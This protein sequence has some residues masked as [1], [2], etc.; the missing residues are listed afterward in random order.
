MLKMD[1]VA[2]RRGPR[3]I[4]DNVQLRAYAG[5]KIG[6]VGANGVGKSSLF[7]LVTGE[8]IPDHG[9]VTLPA[10]WVIAHVGQHSPSTTDCAI[11]FVLDG[12][13][14]LRVLER[15]LE[16][17]DGSLQK[18]GELQT[19]YEAI[20]GYGAR[21]RAAKLLHGLGFSSSD[22]TKSVADFSGGWRMRLSLAQALMCRSDV[23]LLDEP[24][25]H[26]DLDAILWLEGWLK[27][28][29]G[30]LLLISHDREFLDRAIAHVLH[31][32][33]MTA[34]LYTGNY[35]S[36]ESLRA[37]RLAEQAQA[38]EKQQRSVAHMQQFVE[39]FRYKASKARQAQSRL[40]AL[41]KLETIA[42]AHVDSTFEFRISAPEKVP[43]P[44]LR[45]RDASLGYDAN[46]ILRDVSITLSPGRRIGVLGMNGAG[47]STL[48]KSLAGELTALSG[49]REQAPDLVMGYFAQHQLEQLDQQAGPLLHLTRIAPKATTQAMRNYLG[50]FGFRGNRVDEP[51]R[52]FSG[53]EKARL[54]L[55]MLLHKA[56][57]LILLDEPTNHLDLEMR[58]ALSVALQ[59]YAGALVT[60]SHDRHLL[61]LAC[62]ELMLVAN[63]TLGAFDGDL[64]D[65]AS[66]LKSARSD[67]RTTGIDNASTGQSTDRRS[68]RQLDADK[69]RKLAPLKAEVKR[70]EKSLAKFNDELRELQESLADNTLYEDANK[71]RLTDLLEREGRVKKSI[72]EC[73]TTWLE[74]SE[75][76]E[77]A[78]SENNAD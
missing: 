6:V 11:D 20:G 25:N 10:G 75:R 27:S 40:K 21:A 9:D 29:A 16:G 31:L 48:I 69:R 34:R 26:L 46:A 57:N 17:A 67:G 77:L 24:T 58:H 1:A 35:S 76:V 32:E 22:E 73:E 62:D 36:F 42:P 15:A 14:E 7:A 41:A 71:A 28:Y 37:A 23:L 43:N 19:R 52:N 60:V 33:D 63:G 78:V 54:V 72:S 55:A 30:L 12:D 8:L 50:G 53:G 2:L 18:T 45:L 13:N 3:L 61:R 47:K 64:D 68:Q 49:E 4:L 70:I 51:V 39:R 74:A 5:Q 38:Y 66:W 65:Y 56:P 44:L 59:D